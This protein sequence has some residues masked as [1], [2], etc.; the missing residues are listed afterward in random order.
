MPYIVFS[1]WKNGL[2]VR[3]SVLTTQA[4]S[5]VQLQDAIVN[6]GAEIENRY[7]FNSVSAAAASTFGLESIT[8]GLL[9][10]G[11]ITDPGGWTSPISYQR[12]QH[13]TVAEGG[14]SVAMTSVICSCSFGNKA[15]V[16]AKFADGGVFAYSNGTVVPAFRNGQ[17]LTG[18]TG[19]D[20]I[21]Q[22][23]A[24]IIA[25]VAGMHVTA[26]TL[27]GSAYYFDMYSDVGV[28]YV[29][30]AAVKSSAS[31]TITA[32][33][34]LVGTTGLTETLASGYF[35]IFAGSTGTI[36][37]VKVNNIEI[38]GSTVAFYKDI[39]NTSQLLVTTINN[40]ISSPQYVA[41]FGSGQFNNFVYLNASA[42]SGATPNTFVV[43]VTTTGD[44]IVDNTYFTLPAGAG[45]ACQFV[46]IN[47]ATD[48]LGSTVTQA[49]TVPVWAA[50][51]AT[52]INAFQANYN[53]YA[54]PNN[55]GRVYICKKVRASNDTFETSISV[56]L[57]T[58]TVAGNSGSG[59]PS[60]NQ[61][62]VANISPSFVNLTLKKITTSHYG[63][64]TTNITCSPSGGVGPYTFAWTQTNQGFGGSNV[65]ITI[66][67]PTENQVTVSVHEYGTSS[68]NGQIQLLCKVTDSSATPITNTQIVAINC[69]L[70]N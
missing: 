26:I 2:D 24:N 57:T 38:L 48:I 20:K 62:L 59:N 30:N 56:S 39:Y 44:M 11:S 47:G 65:G 49:S 33:E 4:G 50:L 42:G 40:F 45:N 68:S 27:S 22:Q 3:R 21:A 17:V 70:G 19:N 32:A 7:A 58:G 52:T 6:Q 28:S 16:V 63:A 23:L 29:P 51:V 34:R 1:N 54:D 14:A 37:S 13:P 69:S 64:N 18:L 67:N 41:S 15:W 61:G 35:G 36:T 55:S 66:N 25:A 9:T 46:K 60:S 5:L 10:F 31:G 53:A 8:T 43:K 12:L